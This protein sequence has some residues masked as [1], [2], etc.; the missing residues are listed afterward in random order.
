[1]RAFFGYCG[2]Y[3]IDLAN[4][5]VYLYPE[6]AVDPNLVGTS[7]KR[8]Y[9]LEGGLLTFSDKDNAPGVESYAISWRKVK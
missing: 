4:H 1:L 8:P 9:K 2:R 6:V 7:Q 3:E 5:A